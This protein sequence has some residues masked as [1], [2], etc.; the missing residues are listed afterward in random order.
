M[1]PERQRATRAA[2][3]LLLLV[4]VLAACAPRTEVRTVEAL[5]RGAAETPFL[6]H[7]DR[8]EIEMFDAKR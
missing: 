5:L 7:G 8:V 4:A 2:L 3:L 6:K 1:A